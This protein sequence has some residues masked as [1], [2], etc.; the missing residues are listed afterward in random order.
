MLLTDNIGEPELTERICNGDRD[1]FDVAFRR[2]YPGLVVFASQFTIEQSAAEEIVQDFF[3]KL[4]EK[5]MDLV[6]TE[7][8]KSYFFASVK[9]RCFNYLK[10]RKIELEVIEKLKAVSR[11]SL[12]FEPDVYVASE[13]QEKITKAVNAL[14][15]RCREVFIMSRFK[16][17]KN[18]EIAQQLNLSRRTVETHI[19]NAIAALRRDLREY[20]DLVILAWF[21]S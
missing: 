17:M 2:Y 4:W 16:G 3:V 10:H 8:M 9:N 1:A 21:L 19:S 18:D 5:R 11:Q 15:E 12:L 13:L 14:P 20:A 6:F 7:S